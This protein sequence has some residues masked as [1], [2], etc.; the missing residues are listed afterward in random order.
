MTLYG[1]SQEFSREAA[2]KFE[3]ALLDDTSALPSTADTS[4]IGAVGL[5]GQGR[6]YGPAPFER[7]YPYQDLVDL[8]AKDVSVLR[9]QPWKGPLGRRLNC[10]A[11]DVRKRLQDPGS[12]MLVMRGTT[13]SAKSVPGV[14]WL[15]FKTR[16]LSRFRLFKKT[17]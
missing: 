17:R 5:T 11:A 14:V 10:Q 12:V 1:Q 16:Y 8:K 4:V 7:H 2:D 3:Q 13:Y 9:L 6:I 15:Y